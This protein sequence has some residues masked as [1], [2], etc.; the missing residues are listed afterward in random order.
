ME[1]MFDNNVTSMLNF[2]TVIIVTWVFR[3]MLFG[4]T[5][6]SMYLVG[7]IMGV[8]GT[9]TGTFHQKKFIAI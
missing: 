6:G 7:R 1:C 4:D 9:Y 8:S 2:W 5:C 3:R